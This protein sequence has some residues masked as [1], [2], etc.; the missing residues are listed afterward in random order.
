MSVDQA[1]VRLRIADWM[2]LSRQIDV[3]DE[4]R[5]QSALPLEKAAHEILRNSGGYSRAGQWPN[6]KDIDQTGR[7][8]FAVSNGR[9]DGDDFIAA[10]TVEQLA[11]PAAEI[12]QRQSERLKQERAAD[13]LARAKRRVAELGS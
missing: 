11:D 7:A 4:K 12:N 2:E 13:G 3:L 9:D 8:R 1:N 5:E 6:L 10:F